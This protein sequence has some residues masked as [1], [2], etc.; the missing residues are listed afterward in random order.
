MKQDIVDIAHLEAIRIFSLNCFILDNFCIKS[1]DKTWMLKKDVEIFACRHE[2]E[3]RLDKI[4]NAQRK[5]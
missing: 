1:Q 2:T 4:K 5:S 3:E